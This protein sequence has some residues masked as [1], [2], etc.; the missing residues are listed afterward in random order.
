MATAWV[1]RPPLVKFDEDGRAAAAAGG[2]AP[3]P[4][5]CTI[6]IDTSGALLHRRGYRL[7]TAKAPLRE[8]LAAG[9]LL[10]SGWDAASPLLDPFCGSGTIPIEAAC[11]RAGSPREEP[12]LCLHGL[13]QFR[14][15]A[16]GRRMLAEAAAQETACPGAILA[17]D[18]DAGA[19]RIAQANAERAGV[20]GGHP[21][22]LPRVLGHPAAARPGLG[23]HQPA[24]RR[25]RQAGPDLRNLY[26]HLGDVLRALCP[27][28]KLGMLCSSEFLAGHA[29][30]RFEQAL[31]LVNGGMPVKFFMGKV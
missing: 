11:W 27:G 13:A 21:I 19:I 17:S 4:R 2:G 20:A 9:L 29:R 8:T 12:P 1:S 23:G 16:C 31:P 5:P 3:G 18:R 26:A 22:L 24:L 6:S 28:W 15:G 10:A 14:R 25:A 30:L 7:E